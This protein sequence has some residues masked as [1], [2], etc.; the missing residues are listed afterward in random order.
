MHTFPDIISY[1]FPYFLI[2]RLKKLYRFLHID[3]FKSWFPL[4]FIVV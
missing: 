2:K 4:H 3:Y 1:L